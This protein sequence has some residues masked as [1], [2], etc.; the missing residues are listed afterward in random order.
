[1]PAATRHAETTGFPRPLRALAAAIGLG[2]RS[3]G[4]RSIEKGFFLAA[5]AVVL[6]AGDS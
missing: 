3:P 1:M 6:T 5:I 4:P 2:D